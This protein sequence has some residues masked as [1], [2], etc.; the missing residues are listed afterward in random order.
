MSYDQ[1]GKSRKAVRLQLVQPVSAAMD[2][3]LELKEGTDHAAHG[4]NEAAAA[5]AEADAL[6]EAHT[7]H[8]PGSSSKGSDHDQ[9]V[10]LAGQLA[11]VKPKPEQHIK[12][13][14]MLLIQGLQRA[15]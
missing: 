2:K 10:A 1:A 5:E 15:C 9:G 8:S 13:R 14:Y 3:L 7:L 6:H 4:G 12:P 11:G